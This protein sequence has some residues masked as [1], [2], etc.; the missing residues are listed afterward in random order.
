MLRIYA[1]LFSDI[2]F[3]PSKTKHRL[4]HSRI[5]AFLF[6]DISFNPSK[7]KHRLLHSNAMFIPCRK[8]FISVIKKISL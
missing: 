5:Y 3:N 7:T 6:S 8:H 2:S 4:L 1:F